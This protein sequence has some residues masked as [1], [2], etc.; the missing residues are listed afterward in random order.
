M[1][2]KQYM[3]GLTCCIIANITLAQDSVSLS[4][5]LVNTKKEVIDYADIAIFKMPDTTIITNT[6]VDENGKASVVLQAE[7]VFIKIESID[8]IDTSFVAVL[9]KDT[10]LGTLVLKERTKTYL[11]EVTV[12]TQRNTMDL[13]IDKRVYNVADDINAQGA[14]ASEILENV[15]SVTVDAEG[16]VSLRGNGNVRILID[17]KL[18]GFASSADA[19]KML[20]ADAIEKIEIV[21]NASARYDAEG[22]AGIINIILKKG[23][24]GGFNAIA[25]IRAGYNPEYGGGVRFNYKKDK[26]NFFADYNYNFSRHPSTS[27]TYQRV[28]NADTQM[29]Y[30][31]QFL[32]SRQKSRHNMRIGADYD[33]NDRHSTSFD[34]SYRT[35]IGNNAIDRIY[36]NYNAANIIFNEDTRIE[37]NKELEDLIEVNIS[38]NYQFKSR[39]SWKTSMNLY[40]DQDLEHSNYTEYSSLTQLTKTENSSANVYNNVWQAQTDLLIP[41]GKEGKVETGLKYQNRVFDNAFR[42]NRQITAN[43]WESPAR[44]NDEVIYDESV[45]AGYLMSATTIKKWG[46][47]AGVRAEYTAVSTWLKST[48]ANQKDYIN[49]FPS[50]ALSYKLNDKNSF[51]YSLSRRIS[52]PGQWDLLPFMKFG[53]NREMRSGDPNLQPEL[54]YANEVT[55]MHYLNKGSLLSSLYYRHTDNKI[56]RFAVLGNDGIIYRIPMNIAQRDAY[57]FELIGSYQIS[58]AIRFNTNFNFYKEHIKG[59]FNNQDFDRSNFSWTNRTSINLALPK[60][61]KVQ[62]S[63]QYEAPRVSPQ[64]KILHTK[65][66]DIAINKDILKQKASIGFNVR[67]V[68]N[69]RIFRSITE[70]DEIYA[71]TDFQW[72]PR[73]FRVTFTY[74]FNQT[75]KENENF[76]NGDGGGAEM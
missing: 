46:M 33:W 1:N 61:I 28:A 4:F 56:E 19:L 27:N 64:G 67:D 37:N 38:H 54:T 42:Y 8:Y 74:R 24:K 65:W 50:A 13:K 59:T 2:F 47:Q 10:H 41:I 11:D 73:S 76:F 25:N 71:V 43:E 39:G 7:N 63:G 53:D 49:F 44:Y 45:F 62:L 72:R 57:G 30:Q 51:Q 31:Q 70:T 23:K 55:Y 3:L 15:P 75:K 26:W 68:F 52:R 5:N 60:E 17:G 58:R 16:N 21:T 6:M 29:A 66:I 32:Q 40:K 14:T 34:M 36:Q 69:S 9:S 35:G 18:S 20:Q 22:D 12:N 48:T